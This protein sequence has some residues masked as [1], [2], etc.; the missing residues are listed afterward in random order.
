M[1]EELP[2]IS[3]SDALD[4]YEQVLL[5]SR[6]LALRTRHEYL[7]DLTDLVTFLQQRCF[8]S[9]AYR[10]ERNHL[11]RYLAEMD[12]RGLAGNT[13]RRKLASIRSFFIYLHDEELIPA[14]P[15]RKLIPPARERPQPRVL[16]ESEYKRLQLACAH[17]TRDSAIIEV[18]LQTGCR[19]SEIARLTLQSVELPAKISQD[20]GVVGSLRMVG[21]GRKDRTVTL[22]WKACK[23][24]KAY[25]AIR[26]APEN[27]GHLFVTKFRHGMSPRSIENAVGKYLRQAGI[28]NASVHSLR[29]TFATHMVKRGTSLKVV[30]A[31]LGHESLETTEIYISLARDQMDKELQ[32]N[33]L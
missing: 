8:L 14:D 18:L 32:R 12:A 15:T 1:D 23:A 13:R 11:E 27:E 4:R 24:I 26:A 25:L 6:N 21:K 29:H 31:A 2:P 22:N 33:A 3:L 16:S 28:V 19:L 5:P 20:E 17:E 10:V 7:N 30:Q 9:L